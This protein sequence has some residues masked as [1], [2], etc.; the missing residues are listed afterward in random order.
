MLY[1]DFYTDDDR[2]KAGPFEQ[3]VQLT[4]DALR[5]GEQGDTIARW[6]AEAGRWLTD[7]GREWTDVVVSEA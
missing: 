5:V 4:Y 6:D 7:D 2:L 1:V 3:H